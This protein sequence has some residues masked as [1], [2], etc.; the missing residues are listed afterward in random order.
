MC[1][2]KI[3][4]EFPVFC[5]VLETK[6]EGDFRERKGEK[7]RFRTILHYESYFPLNFRVLNF[8]GLFSTYTGNMYLANLEGRREGQACLTRSGQILT[9]PT[10]VWVH[11]ITTGVWSEWCCDAMHWSQHQHIKFGATKSACT[12]KEE[13]LIVHSGFE[14]HHN[15]GEF[16][17]NIWNS[18]RHGG[19]W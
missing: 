9:F 19:W 7:T 8:I 17:L 5:D 11:S 16:T 1:L 6:A 14:K 13:N 18:W 10:T 15:Q 12:W 4:V 3:L 2:F